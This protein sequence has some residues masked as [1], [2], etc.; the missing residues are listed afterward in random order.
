MQQP[1]STLP[2]RP[3]WRR[4]RSSRRW[5]LGHKRA[6]GKGPQVVWG[7]GQAGSC[8]CVCYLFGQD[9]SGRIWLESPRWL[10]LFSSSLMTQIPTLAEGT[11]VGTPHVMKH[12]NQSSFGAESCLCGGAARV[13]LPVCGGGCT[14]VAAVKVASWDVCESS[15]GACCR[16][17]V[18]VSPLIHSSL[19]TQIPTLAEGTLVGTPHLMKQ[20]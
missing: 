9:L 3:S 10:P 16:V 17:S 1:W 18:N 14:C 2:R 11:L 12:S 5:V 13:V 6:G 19:M 15:M 8:V 20:F 4:Q 7:G